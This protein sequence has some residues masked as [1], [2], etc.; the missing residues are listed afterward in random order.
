MIVRASAGIVVVLMTMIA[1]TATSSQRNPE[2]KPDRGAVVDAAVRRGLQVWL[3]AELSRRWLAGRAS[4]DEGIQRL[5][6]LVR[7]PGVVGIRVANEL[8]YE[9][10]F[11]SL[12]KILTFL[13]ETRAAIR[14]VRRDALI[15]VDMVVPELGCVPGLAVA[16]ARDCA[17]E[18]RKRYPALTLESMDAVVSAGAV[19]AI[20]LS[21]FLRSAATYARWG[22]TPE[23]AQRAAWEEA[24]RRGWGR[25]VRLGARKAL[26]HEGRYAGG[27][28]RA[29]A[30]VRTF[31]DVPQASGASWIDIW[32][33]RR[34]QEDSV[35]RLMDPGLKTNHLWKAL[36]AKRRAGST[37]FTHFTPSSV[38]RS[39]EADLDALDDVFAGVYIA[40]GVG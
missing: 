31:I 34:S 5:T 37:L 11:S 20:N 3:D 33:W 14:S 23:A 6:P 2:E 26:A 13:S 12:P 39:V 4:F 7:R 38:E 1:C 21:T 19:D 17:A 35:I 9:D 8:G 25:S 10:G 15:L 32:T 29:L 27:E 28:R 36:L 18:A 30:D 22:T 16:A 40:A 24:V